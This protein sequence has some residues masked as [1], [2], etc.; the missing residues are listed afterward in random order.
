MLKLPTLTKSS[1]HLATGHRCQGG[2]SL[3]EVLVAVIVLSIGL[4]GISGIQLIGLKYNDSAYLRTQA[5]LF[6]YDIMDRMRANRAAAIAGNY[7]KALSAFDPLAAVP[8]TSAPVAQSDL[9]DWY[10]KLNSELRASG[11]IDCNNAGICTITVQWD[12][13]RAEEKRDDTR[14]PNEYLKQVVVAGQL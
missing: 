4:L 1:Q 8:G 12:D 11:A 6:A 9:Y 2:F 13:R 10:R 5:S 14:N 7:D 3:I